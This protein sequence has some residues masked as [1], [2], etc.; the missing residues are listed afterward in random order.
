MTVAATVA[1][2]PVDISDVDAREATRRS[3]PQVASET[4]AKTRSCP[5]SDRANSPD[6]S[7]SPVTIPPA[8]KPRK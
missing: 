6:H 1:G 8:A 3:A 5:G 7:A 2:E 4:T